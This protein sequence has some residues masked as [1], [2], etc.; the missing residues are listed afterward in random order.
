MALVGTQHDPHKAE[1]PWTFL[2]SV[3]L[4]SWCFVETCHSHVSLNCVQTEHPGTPDDLR[5]GEEAQ[6]LFLII[7]RRLPCQDARKKYQMK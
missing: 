2:L 7:L 6:T 5:N 4:R 3:F 1:G